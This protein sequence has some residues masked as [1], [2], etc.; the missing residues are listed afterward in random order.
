MTTL[1]YAAQMIGCSRTLL[2]DMVKRGQVKAHQDPDK[3][4]LGWILDTPLEEVRAAVKEQHPG[5]GRKHKAKPTSLRAGQNLYA[6]AEIA[7]AT[8]RP[9][10]TL[11]SFISRE[12]IKTIRALGQTCLTAKDAMRVHKH[13]TQKPEDSMGAPTKERGGVFTLLARLQSLEA[14]QQQTLEG[15][16]QVQQELAEVKT[17]LGLIVD[18]VHK[19]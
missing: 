3:P 19:W 18:F 11:S 17:S 16:T 15:L 13:Y 9:L 12:K 8:R 5:A 6:I 1:S 10:S 14:L 7:Q 4:R 2:A